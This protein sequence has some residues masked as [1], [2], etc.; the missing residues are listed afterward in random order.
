MVLRNGDR[1]AAGDTELTFYSKGGF[2]RGFRHDKQTWEWPRKSWSSEKI[3]GS[4]LPPSLG[5]QFQTLSSVA[6]SLG[7][8]ST[9]SAAISLLPYRF[10]AGRTPFLLNQVLLFAADNQLTV[11]GRQLPAKFEFA[12]GET[13]QIYSITSN[14]E[15]NTRLERVASY[16]VHNSDLLQLSL[17]EPQT[18]GMKE[19]ILRNGSRLNKPILLTT[20]SLPYSA[21]PTVHYAKESADFSGLF[22][23]IQTEKPKP[24]ENL[25]QKIRSS[26]LTFLAV[27]PKTFEVVTD[28]GTYHLSYGTKFSLGSEDQLVF[29]LFRV[30]FPWDLLHALLILIVLK[31]LFQPPFLLLFDNFAAQLMLLNIDFFLAT[32]FLFAFRASNLYPYSAEAVDLALLAFLLVPYLF[33]VATLFLRPAWQRKEATNFVLYTGLTIVAAHTILRPYLWLVLS[34]ALPALIGAFLRYRARSAFGSWIPALARIKRWPVEGYLALFFVLA[35]LAQWWGA[36]EAIRIGRIRLPLAILY[37]PVFLLFSCYY[38]Y[39]LQQLLQSEKTAEAFR[40]AWVLVM[41][42][43][44]VLTAFFVL[45]FAMSDFGFFLVYCLPLLFMLAGVASLYLREYELKWKVTGLSLLSALSVV[46]LLFS[47][48]NTIT[49]VLPLSYLNHPVAQRILLAVDPR[50]L[51]DTGILSAERQLGHQRTFLAYANSGARGAG[52]MN[53]PIS[54]AMGATALNDNVPSAFLLNDFGVLGFAGVLLVLVLGFG[55]WFRA[56][57]GI[58]THFAKFFSL[59]GLISFVYADLYMLLANCGI[60]LFTGKNVFFWGLNSI[61]DIFHAAMMSLFILLPLLRTQEANLPRPLSF[62]GLAAV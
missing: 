25:S 24:D 26:F 32:R 36:G 29:S 2:Q 54:S 7:V 12:E 28:Q 50:T 16:E 31:M 22:A 21:F 6:Q 55:L 38:L 61:S 53:R 13:V 56:S 30:H 52:Y 59:A 37:H 19:D 43:G 41:K 17:K 40:R 49:R 4:L 3:R 57:A 35:L 48:F 47:S 42:F 45:S 9:S 23:F 5:S 10:S 44:L 15:K 1:I 14:G 51:E 60:L 20:S 33:F 39:G 58:P 62:V 18:I 8:S 34:I 27:K 11:N 46:L